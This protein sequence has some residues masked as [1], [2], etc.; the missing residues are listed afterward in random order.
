MRLSVT[1]VAQSS[2]KGQCLSDLA[3]FTDLPISKLSL[4]SVCDMTGLLYRLDRL[5]EDCRLLPHM[6]NTW[7]AVRHRLVEKLSYYM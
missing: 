6:S 4:E 2:M 3:S 7:G 5:E 1:R